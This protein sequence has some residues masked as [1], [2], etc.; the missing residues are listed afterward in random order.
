M[1]PISVAWPIWE[2]Q[3]SLVGL[4][5]SRQVVGY[6]MAN[7]AGVVRAFGDTYFLGSVPPATLAPPS[8][9]SAPWARYRN[10]PLPDYHVYVSWTGN[11]FMTEIAEALADAVAQSG[12]AVQ[13][14]RHGL[15]ARQPGALNLVVAP[16]EYFTLYE[17]SNEARW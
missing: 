9:R 15:P 8:L 6:W 5:S 11:V 14:H 1:R 13:L 4:R 7:T 12:R 2:W 10:V 3:V 16:H 17:G